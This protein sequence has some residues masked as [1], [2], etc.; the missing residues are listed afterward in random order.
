MRRR[1]GINNTKTERSA[2]RTRKRAIQFPRDMGR[3]AIFG[4]FVAGN[5]LNFR[6]MQRV[7]RFMA[8]PYAIG[9]NLGNSKAVETEDS[10][11]A[12]RTAGRAAR[13]AD[14]CER[15]YKDATGS[16]AASR[17]ERH[18]SGRQGSMHDKSW[19]NTPQLKLTLCP[20]TVY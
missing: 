20:F 16:I 2:A 12:A 5:Q 7:V 3:Q 10:N 1:T 15:R 17:V 11:R 8:I 14:R 4:R 9:I 13:K 18:S 6:G 19:L